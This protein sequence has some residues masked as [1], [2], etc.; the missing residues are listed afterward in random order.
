MGW[1]WGDASAGGSLGV[2]GE[3]AQV[4]FPSHTAVSVTCGHARLSVTV[5][6]SLLGS[7]VAD[8]ELTLGHGCG[9]TGTDKDQYRLEHPLGGCGTT[10]E[11][12]SQ[13]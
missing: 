10:L 13:G 1:F 11:V 9:V 7:P 2:S 12:R 8:G 3:L 4:P 6:S 5:P